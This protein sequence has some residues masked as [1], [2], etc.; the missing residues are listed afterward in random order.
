MSISDSSVELR[1]PVRLRLQDVRIDVKR[2]FLSLSEAIVQAKVALASGEASGFGHVIRALFHSVEAISVATPPE[3]L[4]WQLVQRAIMRAVSE[5]VVQTLAGRIPYKGDQ[6]HLTA[7]I[8]IAIT[9][10]AL[11][12]DSDFFVNPTRLAVVAPIQDIFAEWLRYYDVP[13]QERKA[14]ANRFPS[15][16]AVALHDE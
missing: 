15:Y 7:R 11:Q 14:I 16:F 10:S 13:E 9:D 1:P 3:S 5:L 6:D 8:E 4:G 2:L 12:M